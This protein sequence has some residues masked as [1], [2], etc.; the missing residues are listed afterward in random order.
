MVKKTKCCVCGKEE[1]LYESHDGKGHML[2]WDC[3]MD[4]ISDLAQ[5]EIILCKFC[6][7]NPVLTIY[8]GVPLCRGCI[9]YAE[10][11]PE[12][13]RGSFENIDRF[14][15]QIEDDLSDQDWEGGM[16]D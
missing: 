12:E 7:K 16:S 10:K 2:C 4:H 5:N 15:E 11:H 14:D 9:D 13:C 3:Q 1:D 6:L 8:N